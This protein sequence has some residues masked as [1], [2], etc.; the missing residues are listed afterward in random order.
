ML[1]CTVSFTFY[2]SPPSRVIRENMRRRLLFY[3]RPRHFCSKIASINCAWFV[4]N[5]ATNFT[6]CALLMPKISD[7][8]LN[9][10]LYFEFW[11]EYSANE[12]CLICADTAHGVVLKILF[13]GVVNYVD[14]ILEVAKLS[15]VINKTGFICTFFLMVPHIRHLSVPFMRFKNLRI[16]SGLF[17]CTI[18]LLHGWT[19]QKYAVPSS[20]RPQT[21]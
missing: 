17:I 7:I 21:T 5:C 1:K 10:S 14:Y 8:N 4:L 15:I 20:I 6:F 9:I 12:L 2:A 11:A 13:T 19:D 3:C 18:P 16:K